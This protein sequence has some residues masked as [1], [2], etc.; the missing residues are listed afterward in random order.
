MYNSTREGAIIMN[1]SI[2]HNEKTF[3]KPKWSTYSIFILLIVPQNR[4]FKQ[5]EGKFWILS[6][7]WWLKPVPYCTYAGYINQL[8][9]FL[10]SELLIIGHLT[11]RL[12]K[13]FWTSFANEGILCLARS[14]SWLDVKNRKLFGFVYDNLRSFFVF[15]VS[16]WLSSPERLKGYKKYIASKYHSR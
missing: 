12:K 11:L 3:N 4:H 6:I 5:R 10:K 15:F 9:F 8:S 13:V 1:N 7:M 14:F 16:V 2:C